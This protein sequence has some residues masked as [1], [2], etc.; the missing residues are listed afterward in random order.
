MYGT[1]KWET[2]GMPGGLSLSHI[3]GVSVPIAF[4][5]GNTKF[6]VLGHIQTSTLI[7]FVK[8]NSV[9]TFVVTVDNFEAF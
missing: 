9:Q 2:Y 1:A 8:R 7:R 3:N 5:P 6:V 4:D